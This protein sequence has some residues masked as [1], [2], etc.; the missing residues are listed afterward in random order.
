MDTTIKQQLPA[1]KP[2]LLKKLDY[3]AV[4]VSIVVLLLVGAMRQVKIPLEA[5]LSMLPGFH[6]IL[7]SLAAVALIAAL[8]FVKT[9]QFVKHKNS[10]YVAI[11]LSVLFLLSY[12]LYHFTTEATV[13][14]DVDGDGLLSTAEAA[15]VEGT[16]FWYLL[17]L[18]THIILAAVSFPF[19]LF[20]FNRAYTG[21]F[22]RHKKLARWVYPIWLYVAVTGPICYLML[23]EYY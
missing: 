9:K 18:G 14:G 1:P 17:L 10:I 21:Q 11:G 22:A 6:A 20:T 7:N 2:A 3:A 4:A 15:V 12:V 16:R 19:I 5:D 23:A 13:Y 8:Y